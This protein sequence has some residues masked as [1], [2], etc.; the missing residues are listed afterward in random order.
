MRS[1]STV[2]RRRRALNPRVLDWRYPRELMNPP[3][4]LFFN[5]LQMNSAEK[6]LRYSSMNRIISDVLGRVPTQKSL[7]QLLKVHWCRVALDFH[8]VAWRFRRPN[9]Q[10]R[11]L[12]CFLHG[13]PAES[14]DEL[15]AM[16]PPALGLPPGTRL[17]STYFPPRCGPSQ[18]V[19]HGPSHPGQI[20]LACSSFPS[21][22][23]EQNPGQFSYAGGLDALFAT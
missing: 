14:I 20:F 17:A 13:G 7:R 22:Q 9:L 2:S 1:T 8:G 10:A 12:G 6:L 11:V 23:T 4:R 15:C 18:D 3:A 19:P 21:T 5:V 16:K